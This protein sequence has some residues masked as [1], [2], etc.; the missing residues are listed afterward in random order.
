METVRIESD[1]RGKTSREF[2]QLVLDAMRHA[3]LTICEELNVGSTPDNVGDLFPYL[4]CDPV[5]GRVLG[6]KPGDGRSYWQVVVEIGADSYR[7]RGPSGQHIRRRIT[8]LGATIDHPITFADAAW[9]NQRLRE[10][11]GDT[12][13]WLTVWVTEE[14]IGS[15][16]CHDPFSCA[17]TQAVKRLVRDDFEVSVSDGAIAL[18]DHDT[19]QVYW[20]HPFPV[21]SPI[22]AFIDRFDRGKEVHPFSFVIEL[23]RRYWSRE[24]IDGNV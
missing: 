3:T 13:N 21:D 22:Q 18:S 23:P 5:R 4:C 16:V 19:G 17:I 2:E 14:D 24:A 11:E 8:E 9:C 1:E 15:G 7:F 20:Q 12:I 6:C 10:I